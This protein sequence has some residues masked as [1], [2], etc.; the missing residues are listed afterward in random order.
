MKVPR[1]L[2]V[3]GPS[4]VLVALA[5]CRGEPEP[6]P[7][8]SALAHLQGGEELLETAHSGPAVVAGAG[9]PTRFAALLLEEFDSVHARGLLEFVDGFYRAPGNDG[10]EA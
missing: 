7:D 3:L 4:L 9:G 8:F 10:Y 2:Q 1:S 5:S 6:E